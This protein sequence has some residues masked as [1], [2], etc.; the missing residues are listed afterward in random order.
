M[1]LQQ[2]VLA[3]GAWAEGAGGPAPDAQLVFAFAA[4]GVL[5]D[6]D[7]WSTLRATWPNARIVGCSTAGEIAGNAVHDHSL[8]CT[9]IRFEHSRVAIARVELTDGADDSDVLGRRLAEQLPRPGLRHVFVLSDGLDVNGSA[10]VE[11]MNA[12]LPSEVAV[13]G[14]LSADGPRFE[15][16]TVFVDGPTPSRQI[17][18]IGFYGDRLAIGHG[19]FGGWDPFGVERFITKSEGNVLY[20]LD[21]E[22]V[23]DLYKRYLGEHARGLPS[24]ALRFPLA[25]RDPKSDA[26]AL[27]RTIL[28]FDEDAKT[29]TFAGD[30]PLGHRA[31]LM[32]SNVERLIDGA[33]AAAQ[34]AR[35]PNVETAK[36]ALLVSCVGRKLL[37]N[38]RVEEEVEAVA[39]ALGAN[40]TVAGFYSYGE[41]APSIHAARCDLHNETMVVTTLAET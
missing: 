35:L 7:L 23:L 9:A 27:V 18:A 30:M 26:P 24:T 1:Q 28:S 21:G 39:D 33:D 4:T 36:L 17:V 5:D 14:G 8:V 40:T 34:A 10:L 19:C 37:L 2:R 38:Q 20:Q 41:L 32:M 16:T 25:I 31:R 22:P 6:A 12:T 11:G 15:R 13:T 3:N 29:L